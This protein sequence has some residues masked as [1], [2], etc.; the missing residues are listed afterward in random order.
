MDA[1]SKFEVGIYNREVEEKVREGEHHKQLSDDWADVHYFDV[2][3]PT[4]EDARRKMLQKYPPER[5]YVIT[6]VD[7]IRDHS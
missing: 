6:S 2:A 4:A 5:G 7:P 3:A 1:Q